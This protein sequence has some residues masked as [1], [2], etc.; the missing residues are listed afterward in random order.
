[1]DNINLENIIKLLTELDDA[2]KFGNQREL[3]SN[4]QEVADEIGIVFT[5]DYDLFRKDLVSKLQGE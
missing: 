4:M 1:M 5:S 3:E 2:V